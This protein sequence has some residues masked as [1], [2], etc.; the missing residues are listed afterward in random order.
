[1]GLRL[2]ILENKSVHIIDN[3][4]HKNLASDQQF[5][6]Q[7]TEYRRTFVLGL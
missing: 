5:F 4:E 3:A 1:L 7:N 6:F 2:E